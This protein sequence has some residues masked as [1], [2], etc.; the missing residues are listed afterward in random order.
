MT[1]AKKA[2]TIDYRNTDINSTGRKKSGIPPLGAAKFHFSQSSMTKQRLFS[3][4]G[5]LTKPSFGNTHLK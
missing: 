4:D 3:L 1:T 2:A 5:A